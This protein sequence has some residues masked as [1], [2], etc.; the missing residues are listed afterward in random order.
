MK[1]LA[2]IRKIVS[3]TVALAALFVVTLAFAAPAPPAEKLVGPDTLFVLT[4]PSAPRLA[5]LCSKSCQAQLWRDPAMKPFVDKFMEKWREEFVKPLERELNISFA[6]YAGLAQGQLTLAA[7]LAA[8]PGKELTAGMLF[9]LDAVDKSAQLQTNL[10]QL[11]SKW[12]EAGRQLRTEKIRDIEFS[13]VTLSTNEM[14]KT[15]RRFFPRPLD[16]H[17]LGEEETAKKAEGKS[18]LV[19]GQAGSLLIVANS[20]KM[21]EQALLRLQGGSLPTLSE[22]AAFA[23]NQQRLFREAPLYGWANTKALLELTAKA[24]AQR[25]PNP[26]APNPIEDAVNPER[27]LATSGIMGLNSVGMAMREAGDGIQFEVFMNVPESTRAGV[28]QVLAGEPKETAAPAF[29]PADVARF[30]RSRVDGQKAWAILERMLAEISPQSMSALNFM[31]ETASKSVKEKDPGF[32]VRKN[33]IG[34]LGDDLVIYEKRV[35]GAKTGSQLVLIGSPQPDQLAGAMQSILVFITA[36]AGPP[37]ER[38]FLGRKIYSVPLPATP[39]RLSQASPPAIQRTLHYAAGSGY[40]AFTTEPAILEEFLRSSESQAKPLRETAGLAE[41]A[42]KVGGPGTSFFAYENQTQAV[43]DM[44]E[45]LRKSPSAATNLSG[46]N[47]L[48][49]IPGMAK[50]ERSFTEWMD[51]TLLPPFDAIAKYFNYSVSAL[52]ANTDGMTYKFFAPA[53][54]GSRQNI[55]VK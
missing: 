9:L 11:R 37:S 24:I 2:L 31:L 32:D 14:P 6:N 13:I 15:L 55:P 28:F 23:A 44:V 40:V 36:Q 30:Q 3:N 35:N 1:R 41:A 21:A 8:E 46:L 29:V 39:M 22:Q 34:N 26:Q 27:L 18:E 48:N 17:E 10:S 7:T 50:P 16:Y 4:A 33:L 54:P 53:P 12:V 25:K 45:T 5:E 51:F 20:L 49:S 19:I 38:D 42:Q 47:P 43:R 52:S